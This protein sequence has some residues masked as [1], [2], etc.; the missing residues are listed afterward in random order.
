V[1][2]KTF[3][4]VRP[5]NISAIALAC[6]A[7]GTSEAATTE[8]TPKKAPCDSAA[9]IRP[10]IRTPYDGARAEIR[11]PA[12]NTA[13]SATSTVLREILDPSA[14]SSGAPTTTPRA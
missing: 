6:L 7:F 11:L 2:P 12:M 3:A 8:P 5:V 13:I 14:V 4:T 9:T 10:V 1:V